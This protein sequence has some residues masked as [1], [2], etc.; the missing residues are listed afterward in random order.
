[1]RSRSIMSIR[2][3]FAGTAA[4]LLLA[5]CATM[6]GA[7]LRPDTIY[8]VTGANTLIRFNAGRPAQPD[9][10][11]SISG[12]AAGENLYGIDFRPANGKLYAAGSSGRIYIL[13]TESGAATAVGSGIFT[14][15]IQGDEFGFDFNPVVDRIRMVDN[16]GNNFRLHP[17]TA[18][19][20]DGSAMMDGVQPDAMLRYSREDANAGKLARV[21]AV[22]YTNGHGAKWTTNFA[23]DAAQA[24]LVTMGR[25]EGTTPAKTPSNP[26]E[27]QLFTI[28]RLGVMTG[29]RVAFD[30]HSVRRSAYASFQEGDVSALYEIELASGVASR[31]GPIGKGQLVRGIAI[32][33]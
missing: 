33:P 24:T 26:N 31:I 11:V 9:A 30:I 7:P 8:A 10:S 23:I 25:P 4:A 16:A 6:T 2:R 15:L 20:I 19:L 32:A 21:A 18:T 14:G 28:G 1:M 5:G 29:K 3:T 17:E 22:A 13:D 12:L 27:G